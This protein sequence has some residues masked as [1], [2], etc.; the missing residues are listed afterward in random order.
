M[1][2][3]KQKLKEAF[4]FSFLFWAK[5]KIA[6]LYE[7]VK[8]SSVFKT[9]FSSERFVNSERR[10][11]IKRVKDKYNV[12]VRP[13]PEEDGQMIVMLEPKEGDRIMEEYD[14]MKTKN[15]NRDFYQNK[16]KS[17]KMTYYIEL[18]GEI[19]EE[20]QDLF[21]NRYELCEE[22]FGTVYMKQG[23][24]ILHTIIEKHEEEYKDKVKIMNDQAE[25]VSFD[26]FSKMLENSNVRQN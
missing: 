23:M 11:P 20:S 1:K 8:T 25:R 18:E 10:K 17:N 5:D 19:V 4:P 2:T 9:L 22:A 15:P 14:S 26:D 13:S 24:Q 6:H 7:N 3:P 21:Q 12:E 16:A